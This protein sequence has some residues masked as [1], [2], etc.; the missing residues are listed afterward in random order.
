MRGE[1]GSFYSPRR[2][3]PARNKYGNIWEPPYVDKFSLPAKAWA[4]WR[5]S[6]AGRP[7]GAPTGAAFRA[8]FH[9]GHCQVHPQLVYVGAG[10][11]FVSFLCQMGL[12]WM[13]NAAAMGLSNDVPK[14]YNYDF[15]Y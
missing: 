5:Q 6:G 13:C 8:A 1:G 11:L 7:C 9:P 15:I 3:V 4:I 2:S 10:A 14:T 12:F